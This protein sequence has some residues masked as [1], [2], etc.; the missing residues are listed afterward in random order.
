[1]HLVGLRYPRTRIEENKLQGAL[2]EP[3]QREGPADAVPADK[4]RSSSS[5]RKAVRAASTPANRQRVYARFRYPAGCALRLRRPRAMARAQPRQRSTSLFW[6][7]HL[8]H[9]LVR[10]GVRR[11]MLFGSQP[12]THLATVETGRFSGRWS[13][14]QPFSSYSDANCIWPARRSGR[15]CGGGR[16]GDESVPFAVGSERPAGSWSPGAA[17]TTPVLGDT[18]SASLLVGRPDSARYPCRVFATCLDK[19]DLNHDGTIQT[20]RRGTMTSSMSF[21]FP[22]PNRDGQIT[23]QE[24]GTRG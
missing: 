19:Q 13:G 1:M 23:A 21:T 10:G 16:V 24:W 8:A 9:R 6:H 15:N 2:P 7:G 11:H 20:A 22:T 17:C 3:P 5:S 14:R 12:L 4:S 18:I